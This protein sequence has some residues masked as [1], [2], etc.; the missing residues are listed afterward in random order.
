LT[1]IVADEF[2]IA[3]VEEN[4]IG[5]EHLAAVD[6][7]SKLQPRAP[8]WTT[9]TTPV[10]ELRVV[11]QPTTVPNIDRMK[12]YVYD[13]KAGE[14][15]YIYMVDDGINPAP[16]VGFVF[17][18][19]GHTRPIIMYTVQHGWESCSEEVGQAAQGCHTFQ[20][21]W[22]G[23]QEDSPITPRLFTSTTSHLSPCA[24]DYH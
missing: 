14:G 19:A 13:A 9:Q 15:T 12:N 16:D 10:T 4:I 6:I 8:V 23:A 3:V 7:S 1:G 20:Y 18:I 11:S 5:A 17:C 21:L 2:K 24:H 22:S